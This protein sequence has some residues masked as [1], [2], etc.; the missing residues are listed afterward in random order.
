MCVRNIM[1]ELQS[2]SERQG[3][4]APVIR[5][6]GQ[7]NVVRVGPCRRTISPDRARSKQLLPDQLQGGTFTVTNVGSLGSTMG[8]PIINQPQ[9]GYSRNRCHQ[10]ASG[11]HRGSWSSATRSPFVA[12]CMCLCHTI[13]ASSMGQWHRLSYG[14]TQM[15]W[16]LSVLTASCAESGLI[17]VQS[18]I[19]QSRLAASLK[20]S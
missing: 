1:S 17:A 12:S 3:L 6:A 19:T 9:V 8:T 16:S 2:P 15:S 13:I 4:V 10:E 11:C 5:N 7:M 14:A 18:R 20:R